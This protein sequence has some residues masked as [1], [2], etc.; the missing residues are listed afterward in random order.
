MQLAI[1]AALAVHVLTTIFWAGSTFVIAR[2]D[3]LDPRRLFKPQ[4]GAATLAILSG[5]FLWH[6]FHANAPG[7]A[8]YIL[9]TGVGAALL[10][11]ALQVTAF[12]KLRATNT[13]GRINSLHRPAAGLLAIAA[14]CMAAFRFI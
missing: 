9:M 12:L 8:E 6:L 13:G 1:A 10:A 4:V 11:L 14:V 3:G 2:I 7:R 5:A